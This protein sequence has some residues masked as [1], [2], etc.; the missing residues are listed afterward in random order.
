MKEQPLLY[1]YERVILYLLLKAKET[2]RVYNF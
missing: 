2:N 1:M